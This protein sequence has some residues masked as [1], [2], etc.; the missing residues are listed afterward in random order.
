MER[1]PEWEPGTVAVLSTAGG[2]PH[3]IPVSTALR[4]GDRR[5]L[6]A[7]G[8]GRESLARLRA[9]PRVALTLHGADLAC[10]LY[11]HA[12]IT[13][14]PLREADRVAAVRLEVIE[15]QDHRRDRFAM[16]SGVGWHWTD[17]EA[18]RQDAAVRAGLR[19]LAG[20][21]ES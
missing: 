19:R 18:E 1:V 14:D 7:L 12:A 10:S 20:W 4:A 6:L 3:A 15:V 8:R 16:D 13:E 17:E 9:D 11:G 21:D 2:F 5:V